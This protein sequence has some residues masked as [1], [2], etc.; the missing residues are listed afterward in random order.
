MQKDSFD[1]IAIEL[2]RLADEIATINAQPFDRAAEP[3]LTGDEDAD[4]LL[5]AALAWSPPQ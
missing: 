1:V 4:S 5:E 2:N 3:H